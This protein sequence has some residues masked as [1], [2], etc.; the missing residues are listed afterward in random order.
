MVKYILIAVVCL[1]IGMILGWGM[2]MKVFTDLWAEAMVENMK[3]GSMEQIEWLKWNANELYEKKRQEIL[4]RYNKEKEEM[5]EKAKKSIKDAI[6][7]KVDEI[8]SF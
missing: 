2:S 3:D 6:N 5:I 4:D 7:Q 1:I 8:F